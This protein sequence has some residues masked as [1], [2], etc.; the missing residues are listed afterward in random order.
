M[1]QD[2]E[3]LLLILGGITLFTLGCGYLYV[4]VLGKP[5]G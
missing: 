1:K 4:E 5:Y 3:M 2:L